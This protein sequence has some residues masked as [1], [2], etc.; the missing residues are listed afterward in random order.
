VS[1]KVVEVQ[2]L[3]H[4]EALMEHAGSC[5]VVLF[6]YTRSC[7]ACKAL[8]TEFEALCEEVCVPAGAPPQAAR[9]DQQQVLIRLILGP[10]LRCRGRLS[11]H[12]TVAAASCRLKQTALSAGVNRPLLSICC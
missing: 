6:C 1:G 3:E 11:S 10:E 4:L 9:Q 8:L 2:D 12:H 5:L 7:G